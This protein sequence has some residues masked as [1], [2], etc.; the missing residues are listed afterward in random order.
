MH[1]IHLLLNH[2]QYVLTYHASQK[3]AI[4]SCH[5]IAFAFFSRIAL[6]LFDCLGIV[7]ACRLFSYPKFRILVFISVPK[8]KSE[9]HFVREIKSDSIFA[10]NISAPRLNFWFRRFSLYFNQFFC[11]D[12][13]VKF[14]SF[15]SAN[16]AKETAFQCCFIDFYCNNARIYN[17]RILIY[18]L[19]VWVE[20]AFCW[21]RSVN[22][23]IDCC[24]QNTVQIVGHLHC[25]RLCQRCK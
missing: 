24:Q 14:N 15:G 21:H 25:F 20:T 12:P 1:F 9:I 2:F 13:S 10:E 4:W 11:Y 23:F 5:L 19:M 8:E 16:I 6:R 17:A 7:S 3:L 22:Y 18:S